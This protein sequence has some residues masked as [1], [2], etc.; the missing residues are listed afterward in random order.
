[1]SNKLKTI[2][3]NYHCTTYNVGGFPIKIKPGIENS[4][5]LEN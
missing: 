2:D 5:I 4:K 1:M 3:P